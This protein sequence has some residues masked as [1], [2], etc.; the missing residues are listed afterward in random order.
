MRNPTQYT[1]QETIGW[2]EFEKICVSIL[3]AK[4]YKQIKSAGR[5]KDGGR[6]A[7][8]FRGRSEH[9]IFQISKEKNPLDEKKRTN[10]RP[11]KF[12]REYG[13]WTSSKSTRKFVFI[14]SETLGS[15]KIDLMR[16]LKHPKVD[17]IDIDEIVNFLDYDATGI[18]IKRQYAIFSKDLQEVFGAEDRDEKLNDIAKVVNEDENYHITTVLGPS[19]HAPRV[20]NAIFSEQNGDV[21]RYFVPKSFEHYKKA[22]PTVSMV[23]AAPNTKEGIAKLSLFKQAILDGEHTVIPPEY[24]RHLDF[25]LGARTLFDN[26]KEGAQVRIGPVPVVDNRPRRIVVRSTSRP[27]ISVASDLLIK[28]QTKTTLTMDNSHLN[29]PLDMQVSLDRSSG[30]I[31]FTYNF[32]LDRCIDV[33]SAYRYASILDAIRSE[34]TEILFDD[35]GIERKIA[36]TPA[37]GGT[38]LDSGHLRALRDM[39]RIQNHFKVRL[40]N[41]FS[42]PDIGL[43]DKDYWSIAKLISIIETGKA[44]VSV[45]NISFETDTELLRDTIDDENRVVQALALSG[46]VENNLLSVMGI[47][48]FGDM[49]IIF[50]EAKLNITDIGNGHSKVDVEPLHTPYL[51]QSSLENKPPIATWNE[52]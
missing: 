8:V 3:F 33:S 35:D 30:A 38:P 37:R 46:D 39:S 31:N 5:V 40:P 44:E 45:N 9:T 26:S 24:I 27:D 52:K 11:S 41:P 19:E 49:M 13:K 12:W 32:H 43:S 17:I 18:E 16:D 7:V 23:L 22:A 48:S 21:I 6:D 20:S 10:K 50:P 36:D 42:S 28:G 2:E 25:K 14:S 15:S 29:T 1:I 4:G 51:Q 47:S 34:T